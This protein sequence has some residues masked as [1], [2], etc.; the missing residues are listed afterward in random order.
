MKGCRA[1]KDDEITNIMN[2]FTSIRDKALFFIGISTGF[3]ISELLSLTVASVWVNGMPATRAKLARKNTKG[4]IEGRS[5]ALNQ[6]AQEL[7]KELVEGY[8]LKDTDPLFL[9]RKGKSLGRKQAWKILTDAFEKANVY[10]HVSCHSM[11]KTLAAKVFKA[12]NGSLVLTQKALGHKNI[13]STVSYLAVEESEVDSLI[14][15]LNN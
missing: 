5:V 13:S 3:R 12:S 6:K 11:R 8:G 14:M 4:K 9:S 7:I 10:E 1:L 2:S 15:G